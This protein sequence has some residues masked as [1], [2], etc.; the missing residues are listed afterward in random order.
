MLSEFSFDLKDHGSH[1]MSVHALL[2]AGLIMR[3]RVWFVTNWSIRRGN[4]ELDSG[5]FILAVRSSG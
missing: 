2:K 5:K 3:E 4:S 1:G